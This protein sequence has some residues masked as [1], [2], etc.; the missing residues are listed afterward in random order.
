MAHPEKRYERLSQDDDSSVNGRLEEA[1]LAESLSGQDNG[2]HGIF[3]NLVILVGFVFSFDLKLS[4]KYEQVEF[5]PRFEGEKS[6]YMG[7]PSPMVDK[8]WYD[9]AARSGAISKE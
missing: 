8:L 6:P 2:R 4:I 7:D 9:L 1:I 5:D 3:K